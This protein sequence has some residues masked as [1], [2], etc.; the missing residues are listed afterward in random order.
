MVDVLL[1]TAGNPVGRQVLRSLK[2]H[3]LRVAVSDPCQESMDHYCKGA[4]GSFVL[5]DAALHEVGHVRRLGPRASEL[6]VSMVIPVF[7]PEVLA[8]NLECLP[9][10]TRVP[11]DEAEKLARMD[12]KCLASELATSLNIPQ[13]EI[14]THFDRI[15]KYPVVFKRPGGLGGSA[16]YF[17]GNRNSLEKLVRTQDRCLVTEFVP[18]YDVSVDALRWDGYFRAGAYRVIL[19]RRKGFS[20]LRESV[21]MPEAIQYARRLLDALDYKGACGLDFRVDARS[22]KLLFLECNPRFSG[23]LYSQ[24][25]AGFDLPWELWQLCNGEDPGNDGKPIRSG[26]R[27]MS[28]EGAGRLLRHRKTSLGDKLRCLFPRT[29]RFD[30]L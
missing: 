11:V 15:D 14:Y 8:R 28:L 22:G 20:V 2:S 29:F 5:P 23:G 3:G 17:P 1:T 13:P 16:V 12:D 19:P 10:G 7:Y 25:A 18:G 9:A 6:S 30:E 26:V 4:E 24:M 21:D 27:T